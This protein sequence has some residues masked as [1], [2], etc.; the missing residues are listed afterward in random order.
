MTP[1]LLALLQ[2]SETRQPRI[3]LRCGRTE[4]HLEAFDSILP[5]RT[6]AARALTPILRARKTISLGLIF[7]SRLVSP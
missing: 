2:D 6:R 3:E 5:S 4:V 7:S 1:L